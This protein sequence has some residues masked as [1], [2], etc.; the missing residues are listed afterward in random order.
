VCIIA[1]DA[2]EFDLV[3]S[4][5]CENLKQKEYGKIDQSEFKKYSPTGEPFT[6]VVWSSF[7]TGKMPEQTG[8][9]IKRKQGNSIIETAKRAIFRSNITD[10][11]VD[12][13]SIRKWGWI[14]KIRKKTR[15]RFAHTSGVRQ[16]W[17][18]NE[19]YY[20]KKN[21]ETIFDFSES[22][23]IIAMP[24]YRSYEQTTAKETH[25]EVKKTWQK[26]T[27]GEISGA[28]FIQ[29]ELEFF[30]KEIDEAFAI[31]Q[32]K[33]DLFVF[34]T[35]MIDYVGHFFAW[36]KKT[37]WLFY[38]RVETFIEEIQNR[39]GED[40]FILVI[41]DHGMQGNGVHSDH[42]FYSMNI[43]L[44]LENPKITDFYGIITEKLVLK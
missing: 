38:S 40:T 5:F 6:P 41:S 22:P 30:E 17:N 20:K 12:M 37:M 27:K 15:S 14:K 36:N 32:G 39:F 13:L 2:L 43:H 25:T 28:E 35:K 1:I 3:H 4:F 42:A 19:E 9:L 16:A 24:A 23:E 44:N 11:L 7:I 31:L 34:Y 8:I 21:L 26:F 10:K 33:W 18:T 29:R